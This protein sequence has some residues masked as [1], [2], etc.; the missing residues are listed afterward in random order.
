[1]INRDSFRDS[2]GSGQIIVLLHGFLASSRYW[3]RL[4]PLLLRDGYRVV[5]ID[6]LGFGYAPK[7]RTADYTYEDHSNHLEIIL[8][9]LHITRPFILVGHSMGASIAARYGRLHS[10]D[11]KALILIH[12][13]LYK[14][15]QNARATLRSTGKLYRFLLDSPNRNLVWFALKNLNLSILG[16]HTHRA[17]EMSL[18]NIIEAAEIFQD[19]ENIKVRTLLIVGSNDR[20]EYTENLREH[21]VNNKM[22][23]IAIEKTS[24]HSPRTHPLLVKNHIVSLDNHS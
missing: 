23:T 11:I 12:P 21:S 24:H 5:T 10:D 8:K 20:K 9:D 2:G 16:K 1:V 15:P 13:P 22:V 3:S 6:L 14:D 18:I 4:Q 7:P 19:I 17:R